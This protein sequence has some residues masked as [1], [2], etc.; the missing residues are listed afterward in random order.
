MTAEATHTRCTLCGEPS[1]GTIEPPRRTLARGLDPDDESYSVTVILPDVPLCTVH[2][3]EVHQGDRLIGWCDDEGCRKYGEL[4]ETSS[5]GD[6]Y[7]KL[8]SSNR[9]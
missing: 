5:C 2:T 4:G 8:G 9:S 3:L 7:K 1:T 6:P